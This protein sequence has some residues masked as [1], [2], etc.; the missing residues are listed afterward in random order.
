MT[1]SVMLSASLPKL[2]KVTVCDRVHLHKHGGGT[3]PKLQEKDRLVGVK[4]A[5]GP[6]TTPMPFKGIDCGLPSPLSVIVTE[7]FRGPLAVGLK[8][9]LTLQLAPT[10][11]LEPQVCVSEKSP[12][13]VPVM[14]ML[15]MLNAFAPI[16]VSVK[17]CAA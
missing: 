15:P 11:K 10:G 2:L 8:V 9:T 3:H 13:F 6:E 16:L 5:S 12:A 14:A 7:A 17:A 1:I 4:V